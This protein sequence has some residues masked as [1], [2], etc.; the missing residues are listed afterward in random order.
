VGYFLL[1]RA[2]IA[3]VSYYPGGWAEWS[4]DPALPVVRVVGAEEL[5]DRL[6]RAR[7]WLGIDAPPEGLALFDVRHAGD[8]TGG[9]IPGA[10][11][12]TSRSFADSLDARIDRY[13][14]DLDRTTAPIVTYCYGSNCIRS[15]NCST[16]AARQGFVNVERFY[17]G[18][19][20]WRAIGGRIIR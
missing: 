1:R 6:G 17:G 14:P 5:L 10:V 7:R 2:G 20:E 18:V 11:H 15:R 19:E 16:E 3:D 8:Y 12:L 4:A 13:W 9:H